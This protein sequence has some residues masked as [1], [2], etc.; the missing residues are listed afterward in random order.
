ADAQCWLYAVPEPTAV[1]VLCR[2]VPALRR[3]CPV[4][5][6]GFL[7]LARYDV[8]KSRCMARRRSAAATL[9]AR[10][11]IRFALAGLVPPSWKARNRMRFLSKPYVLH[12]RSK[13][14][15]A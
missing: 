6:H 14:R 12:L 8:H 2:P 7:C 15:H 9:I 1:F 10:T 5:F 4:R 3:V 11:I 13:D